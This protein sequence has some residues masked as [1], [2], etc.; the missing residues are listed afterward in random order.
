MM[1]YHVVK[2][3]RILASSQDIDKAVNYAEYKQA[4]VISSTIS[5]HF[6]QV[7][8][9]PMGTIITQRPFCAED[10]QYNQLRD[11]LR[12]HSCFIKITQYAHANWFTLLVNSLENQHY[13]TLK[14]AVE[15]I[16]ATMP[17][18]QEITNEEKESLNSLFDE[19]GFDIEI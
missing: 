10:R 16:V 15:Q 18:G 7:E 13:D 19:F 17:E 4:Q 5:P 2:D 1:Y 11:A 3:G 9:K 6:A 8:V 12:Q 14:I